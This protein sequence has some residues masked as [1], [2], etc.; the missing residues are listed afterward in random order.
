MRTLQGTLYCFDGSRGLATRETTIFSSRTLMR[1]ACESGASHYVLL[2]QNAR[3][4]IRIRSLASKLADTLHL[5][6]GE[7]ER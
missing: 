4:A 6:I 7:P 3:R 2:M 5:I 1:A